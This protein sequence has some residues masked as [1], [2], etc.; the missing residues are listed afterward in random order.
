MAAKP[1][2]RIAALSTSYFKVTAGI[3]LPGSV[4]A[5]VQAKKR[6]NNVSPFL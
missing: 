5:F 4:T 2:A 6:G 3:T 1:G